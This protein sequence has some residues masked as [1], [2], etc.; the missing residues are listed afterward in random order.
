MPEPKPKPT[1]GRN[2]GPKPPLPQESAAKSPDPVKRPKGVDSILDFHRLGLR[3]LARQKA[4]GC[5]RQRAAKHIAQ[6]D[7]ENFETARKAADFASENPEGVPEWL[8]KLFEPSRGRPIGVNHVRR[9]LALKAGEQQRWLEKAYSERWPVLKFKSEIR[10][11]TGPAPVKGGK[12]FAPMA[13]LDE[14]L[15]DIMTRGG[16]WLRR[17]QSLLPS[18]ASWRQRDGLGTE[19]IVTIRKRV[20]EARELLKRL[21]EEAE[22]LR[23]RLLKA[24]RGLVADPDRRKGKK[25]T[26]G[27]GD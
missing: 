27:L 15:D 19:D 13:D 18:D 1:S 24:S 2:A 20:K 21:A 9:V 4:D 7:G 16:E 26:G 12:P 22:I 11:A 6:D 25:T 17:Y 23:T 10:R 8:K 14:T 3:V 5:S